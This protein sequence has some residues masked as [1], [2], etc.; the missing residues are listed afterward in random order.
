MSIAG[1]I[2]TVL[3]QEAPYA[4]EIQM[5]AVL[6]LDFQGS[7]TGGRPYYWYRGTRYADI[8]KVPGWS[9][10][11]ASEA[12]AEDGRGRYVWY[13]AGEPRITADRGLW[14][15]EARTNLVAYSD[16]LIVDNYWNKTSSSTAWVM[17]PLYG[18]VSRL[19]N[20]GQA[21][22]VAITRSG[23]YTA[24]GVGVRSVLVKADGATSVSLRST[25]SA[26]SGYG[27]IAFTFSTE[28]VALQGAATAGGFTKLA[29]GWY[30]LWFAMNVV[31][32]DSATVSI[33]IRLTSSATDPVNSGV[34]IKF[35]QAEVGASVSSPIVTN[36]VAGTRATDIPLVNLATPMA[37]P[38]TMAVAVETLGDLGQVSTQTFA[39]LA[40]TAAGRLTLERSAGGTVRASDG[41][42]VITG[43]SF[44]KAGAR[45]LRGAVREL[46]DGAVK[47]AWDGALTAGSAVT[48][49]GPFDRLDIGHRSGG[50]TPA[51]GVIRSLILYGGMDDAQLGRAA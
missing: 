45:I 28:A 3:R 6:I 36:G 24:D 48:P 25:T 43:T 40:Q 21:S 22:I 13:P 20:D 7:R 38:A 9:F 42:G 44:T 29:G 14:N 18:R 8:R 12:W 37:V 41:A 30:R 32:S 35:M 34:L 33:S 23:L 5:G 4:A 47:A 26:T 50:T 15:E 31:A 2:A 1:V 17:D 39:S 11:R 19:N 51:N 10:S 27:A 16:D 49:A 46:A